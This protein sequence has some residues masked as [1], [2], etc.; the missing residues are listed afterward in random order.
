MSKYLVIMVHGL[1]GGED[2]WK[3]ND[4]KKFNELLMEDDNIK[5]RF[6]F[7]E[8]DYYT[9]IVNLKNTKLSKAI[10][11]IINIIPGFNLDKP[12]IKKNVSILS[13]ADELATYVEC[14]TLDYSK[15][16]FVSHSMGGLISKK[17]ILDQLD[18]HHEDITND[19]VGYISL[20]TPHRGSFPSMILGPFNL[21]AKELT[22]LDKDMTKLNDDW[23]GN[24]S[25]LPKSYYLEAEYDECVGK[26]SAS[27]NT[28]KKYKPKVLQ[29]DHTSICK[30]KNAKSLTLKMVKKQLLEIAHG[31]DQI[32]LTK[33]DYDSE[34]HCY[35]NEIFVVK[36]F[37]ASIE[38]NLVEDAK[39]SFFS[40]RANHEVR[41]KRRV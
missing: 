25:I 14:E 33:L 5:Q 8:F 9:E 29:E 6:D 18:G 16:I 12:K 27:P 37:L 36:L 1:T 39:E 17:F 3:N 7:V 4:G 35:D 26:L 2:T 19:T 28:N 30:P 34:V 15:I 21:N 31:C 41:H 11:G 40:C 20:A 10:V 23:V 38:E 22:P 24:F 13:I 32:A